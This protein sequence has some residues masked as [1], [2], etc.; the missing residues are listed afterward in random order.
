MATNNSD[1]VGNLTYQRAI[2][3]ARNTEGELNPQVATFLDQACTDIWKRI[4][5]APTTYLLTRDEFAVFNYFRDRFPGVQAEDAVERYWRLG[6][7]LPA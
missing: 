5:E 3:I 6:P 2:D 1:N 7:G 4:Q